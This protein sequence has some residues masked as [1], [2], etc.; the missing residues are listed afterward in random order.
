MRQEPVAS[1]APVQREQIIRN[2]AT[3]PERHEGRIVRRRT[4][5]AAIVA[6]VIGIIVLIA[7]IY[8]VLTL[9]KAAPAPYSYI[10]A[11]IVGVILIA[12]GARLVTTRTSGV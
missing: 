12:V 7:G 1:T 9:A 11:F 5:T 2:E 8:L 10:V 3:V 4:N 6:I